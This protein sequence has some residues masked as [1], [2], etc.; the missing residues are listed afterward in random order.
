MEG[1]GLEN[2]DRERIGMG[3]GGAKQRAAEEDGRKERLGRMNGEMPLFDFADSEDFDFNRQMQLIA[4]RYAAEDSLLA[5]VGSGD[6]EAVFNA[7]R[8]YGELMRDPLQESR[9][10][11]RDDLRDFKNS[12][13][14]MNTLFRKTIEGRGVHPIYLHESSSRFGT[15]IEQAASA[16]GVA[17]LIGEMVHVYCRLVREYSMTNYTPA[18]RKA[19]LYID[20]NLAS[21][22]STRDIAREL[23]LTPNYLSARFKQ[24]VGVNISDYLLDRRIR[25]ACQLLT[26]TSM[27]VQDI[28]AKTGMGDA[29]YFSKQFRRVIGIT[30]LKYRK[31]A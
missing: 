2:L 10:T 12:V 5:A 22:I 16:A 24:E 17:A 23:F 31:Q 11:S 6:E 3:A 30:P 9:P 4:D 1:F 21:P 19:L 20:M 13:Q 7:F 15:A 29:S 26:T 27:S 8:R 18:V 25:L 28:A 14:T